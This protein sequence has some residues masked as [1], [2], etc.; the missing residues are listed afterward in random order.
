MQKFRNVTIAVLAVITALFGANTYYLHG[1]YESVKEQYVSMAKN[2]L[3]QA[4]MMETVENLQR[5]DTVTNDDMKFSLDLDIFQRATES[6]RVTERMESINM[7]DSLNGEKLLGLFDSFNVSMAS[8]F[9]N[10]ASRYVKTANYARLDTLFMVELNRIGLYPDRVMVLP[11]DSVNRAETKSMWEI[12]YSIVSGAPVRYKAYMSPPL[13]A[14][15]RQTAGVVVTMALIMVML[16]FAFYYLIHTVVKLRSIEEMKDDFTNNMTHE[17]K[18]PIA[19]AYSA[20]DTLL[21][22]GKHYNAERRER[23]LKMALE[24]LTKLSELVERILSMS[25]ER[26]KSLTLEREVIILK[27][28]LEAIAEAQRLRAGK[29]ARISINVN[30]D[31]LEIKGDPTHLANVINNLVDNAIKYSGENV[32]I[33]IE[34]DS[35]HISVSDTGNGIPAKA[36]PYIFNKFYRVPS[37]NRQDVRGYGIGLYYVKTIVEKM[38]WSIDVK[39]SVGKGSVFMINIGDN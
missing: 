1:L 36:I 4:D 20:N 33:A 2:C 35:R 11:P 24:Q 16:A 34:A 14:I 29:D 22:C 9:H 7:M 3:L 31:T 39:S 19:V 8:S 15:L 26:R 12:D 23:Y 30:P 25:M 38:G 27:P 28:F 13:G 5:N 18:T 10:M 6:G 37:G 21:N 32:E 17:L